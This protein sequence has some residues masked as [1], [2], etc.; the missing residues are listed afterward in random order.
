MNNRESMG[1]SRAR[2]WRQHNKK[3]ARQHPPC[4]WPVF[5]LYTESRVQST[6][7]TYLIKTNLATLRGEAE[8]MA[9]LAHQY[10]GL[11]CSPLSSSPHL[12]KPFSSKPQKSISFPIVSAVAITGNA[13]T[14]E[15]QRLKEMFEEAYERCRTAPTEGISFTAEDFH[16]ALDKYDF[17]SEIGTKV[18]TFL[19]KLFYY[20][21]LSMF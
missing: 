15:R 5:N 12:S 17:N 6:L 20:F 10:T 18:S 3:E 9:S 7:S 2:L 14:K 8:R 1:F 4:P 11:R 21:F 16:N 19:S 13:Q